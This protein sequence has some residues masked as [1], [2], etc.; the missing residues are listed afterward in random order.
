MPP[1]RLSKNLRWRKKCLSP[2]F[3]VVLLLAGPEARDGEFWRFD[4]LDRLGDHPTRA[5][6]HPQ[7]VDA[8]FGK[9]VLFD[10]LGDALFVDTHPLA[11]A[12]KFTWE[13]LFRPDAGGAAEQR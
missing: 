4:R 2:F 11:G 13:V 3:V 1:L 7:L 5:V 6:G 10:G 8:V 9:A 12:E